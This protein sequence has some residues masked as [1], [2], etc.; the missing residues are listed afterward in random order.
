MNV[1]LYRIFLW[2]TFP[3]FLIAALKQ[4]LSSKTV[5][6]GFKMNKIFTEYLKVCL[7]TLFLVLGG[8]SSIYATTYYSKATGLNANALITWTVNAD[9]TGANPSN[10]TTPGDVFIIQN[11]HTLT[12]NA[13]WSLTGNLTINN[14]GFFTTG[15]QN[16][17]LGSLTINSGGTFTVNFNN[18]KTLTLNGATTIGGTLN[19]TTTNGN[20]NFIGSV[21]VNSGGTWNNSIN[22]PINFRGGV[23][24]NGTFTAGAGVYT[25]N[26]NNQTI[27]GTLSIPNVTVAGV[28]L[29]NNGTLSVTTALT[30]TGGLTQ[31]SGSVLNIG[32]PTTT[33][34]T[35]S[36]LTAT[37][38]GNTVNYNGA[39]QT[40]KATTYDNLTLSGTGAKTFPSG[41]TTVNNVLSIENG[42]NTNTFTGTLAYGTAAT[43]QYN[44]GSSNRTVSTEWPATFSGSG[45]VI[46]KGPGTITLNEAKTLS[47]NVPLTIN[48]GTL[49]S[50]NYNLTLGGNFT[51]NATFTYGTSTVTFNGTSPQ[52]IGGSSSTT[53]YN[54]TINNT[55]TSGNNTVTIQKPTTVTNVFTLTSGIVNTTSTNVLSVTN[56]AAGAI[57]GGSSTSF[58]NGPLK[59]SLPANY[60]TASSYVFPVGAGTSYYPF[61]LV[62]P[63]TG[64]SA[65]TVQ[66]EAKAASSGGKVD[67]TLFSLSTT[68]YWTMTTTGSFTNSSVSVSRPTAIAPYR[69]IAGST[70]VNGTY[71]SLGG[72]AGTNG[73]TNSNSIGS[74]RY[75]ALASTP[76]ISLSHGSLTGFTYVEGNG[77]S[78]IQSFTVTG[79]NLIDNVIITAP[80]DFEVSLSGGTSF[81]GSS[82]LTISAV[83]GAINNVPVYVRMKAGLAQDSIG[84]E[85]LTVS[86]TGFA[87]QTVSLSGTVTVRPV[88]TLS[89]TSLSEFTY[90]YTAGPSAQQSFT[91]SGTYLQG[92]VTL[93]APLYYEISTTSGSGFSSTLTLTPTSGTLNGTTIYVRLRAGF[94]VTTYNENIT[95]TSIYAETKTVSLSGSVTAAATL[96]ASPSILSG[97][98]YTYGNGPSASQF[99]TL[100]GTNLSSDITVTAPTNFEISNTQ[101]GTYTSSIS[102]SPTNRTVDQTLY[103]RLKSGLAA[104]SYGLS[105]ITLSTIGAV[106]K[107]VALSGKV[108]N[109]PTLIVSPNILGGFSYVV[110]DGPS[111]AQSFTVSGASLGTNNISITPTSQ[112]EVSFS[113]NSG[114]QASLSLTPTNGTVNATTIYVRMKTG[115]STAGAQNGSV[116]VSVTGATSQTVTLNGQVYSQP[117]ITA[118]GGGDYCTGS[119]INLISSGENIQSQYWTGPNSFYSILP[120]P[121]IANSTPAMSGTYTVTGNVVVSGN[122]VSNGDFEMGNVGF[123]SSYGYPA[124][125]FTTS[126][127]VPEGLYAIVNFPSTVHGN[128]TSSGDHTTGTGKQMVVNGATNPGMVVWS[129]SVAVVPNADYEFSYWVQTVVNGNDS[130]PA[131]LQLYINGVASGSIFTA[132]PTTAKWIQFVFNTNAGSNT[133]LN[134]EIV[135]QN[136]IPG[137][138][139]FALDDIVL[140]QIAT[141]SSSTNVT[142][143]NYQPVSVSVSYSP[144]VV[145][146][147]TPVT[148]TATP[149]NGGSAPVYEWSVNGTVVGTNSSTYTYTPQNGDVVSCKLTSS[150]PCTTGN[151]AT[152]S[153]TMTV[154]TQNNYWMGAVSSTDWGTA[155]NWTAGYVPLAGSNVEYATAANNGTAAVK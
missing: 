60:S 23:T 53:F 89:P 98:I 44:A 125:P 67:G 137:G 152:S 47:V 138:N 154:L 56:T 111:S 66:I 121:S 62:N 20:K 25:F 90:I 91:V 5:S 46:V 6:G 140:H 123:G 148:F 150:Y 109:S 27:N 114:F 155:S 81:S 61:T 119:T 42:T 7:F 107:T 128:F 4:C 69:V 102:L 96:T 117:S 124:E 118:E 70:D 92:N 11:G 10:F 36:T 68:E 73:V 71:T 153:K 65:P 31:S 122:L 41:T 22:E 43:L 39:A 80:T 110:G 15:S 97:F 142:V 115:I 59:R 17:T 129:Q 51:N 100:K 116:S 34:I 75:F 16:T 85:Q 63:T 74:N 112:Y 76:L 113:A 38:A 86:T 13:A 3:I 108:V 35:I 88:I 144:S 99:F 50:G 143:N 141:V 28:T 19:I 139:D 93:T 106:T 104:G 26:T 130:N 24:N 72:M 132:N 87:S 32:G 29:T 120:N 49:A 48:S 83:D 54:L 21:T 1:T 77:P 40:L 52:S 136:T 45:G 147:N 134:L 94:G 131:Q 64:A 145:Y 135:N 146:T 57:S 126:S 103:V 127:L 33:A 58:V 8:M 79:S 30:G 151:P 78:G 55:G 105:N 133:T 82:Q 149:T 14:G 37:A 84:P 12:L 9:G 95:A 2:K 101:N 18:N